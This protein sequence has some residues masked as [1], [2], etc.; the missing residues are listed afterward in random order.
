MTGD[1]SRLRELLE[2]SRAIASTTD[3][4]ECLH[5]VAQKACALVDAEASLLLVA[6]P[7]RPA[8]LGACVGLPP[9]KARD[10]HVVLD[11]RLTATLRERFALG[12]DRVLV[13]VPM[14]LRGDVRGT[15]A[16]I[17]RAEPG[18][19]RAVSEQDEGL[20]SALADQAALAL[21]HKAHLEELEGALAAAERERRAREETLAAL[22]AERR[23]L[24]AVIE[25]SPT[26]V[27]L[28]EGTS[29]A[30]VTANVRADELFG[31]TIA[32]GAGTSQSD[33]QICAPDG[34]VL[35]R[36]RIPAVEALRGNVVRR[37][38]SIRRPDGTLVPVLVSA[39]PIPDEHGGVLG[40]VV[41]YEDISALKE[42]QRMREEWT[43][44]VAHDLRQPVHAI[45]LRAQ[46]LVRDVGK[47]A[48]EIQEA[49]EHILKSLQNL[50]RMIDDLL[51]SSLVEAQRLALVRRP[52]DV[53][54]V[55]A[56]AIE[57]STAAMGGHAV[58]LNVPEGLPPVDVDSGRIEQVLMNLLANA[59][60][61]G[62]ADRPI[63][64]FAERRAHAV[65][66]GVRNYGA[67]IDPAIAPQL[68][69]RFRRGSKGEGLGLGLYISKGIVEGHGGK[70][71]VESTKEGRTT[72][73]F[74][75]P[76]RAGDALDRS[77][78]RAAP[79]ERRRPR[80]PRAS[81]SP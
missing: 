39:A 2:I 53:S 77:R 5:L 48:P 13:A 76:L 33:R 16:V 81:R 60:R 43:S 1:A 72:F 46:L 22:S 21:G 78:R 41:L 57:R 51:D 4:D 30:R 70:I 3:Y 9:E 10:L 32:H 55:L 67:P 24:R 34:T 50:N 6:E 44:V 62:A 54:S 26:A 36:A 18:S 79:S 19:E 74:T 45:S 8:V 29:G 28:V 61:Y 35:P 56:G 25:H 40:A 68:F 73:H 64:V 38:L 66:I 71:W 47:S 12:P 14:I 31:R 11:E 69:E 23:W 58:T 27:L 7:G 42:L 75:L 15:L 17:Q 20:L 59:A 65:E 80:R 37:E 63:E 52:H 49:L